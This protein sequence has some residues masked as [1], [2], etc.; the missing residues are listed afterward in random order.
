M[1]LTKAETTNRPP[2]SFSAPNKQAATVGE[3]N[4]LIDE[5][6]GSTGITTAGNVSVGGNLTVTGTT[7]LNGNLVLGDAAADSLIVN[8][9]TTYEGPINYSNATGI[10]AFATG[11]QASATAL[12]EET[13]N[14]TTVATAGDSVKLPAAEAGKHVYVKNSGATA[15][16]IFPA[17]GDS[18]DALAVNLAIRIQP[19]S[20]VNFRAKDGTVWESNVDQ[21]FTL[22]APTT[23]TGQLELKAASSAGNTVTTITNASQA[24]ART[25]TVPDAGANADFVMTAGAQT[26]GGVKD[27]SASPNF[28]LN[29]TFSKEV[30]H[31]LSVST[32]TTAA[33]AGGNLVL[34]SGIGAT[35][36]AGG[37]LSLEAGAGGA[38][39]TGGAIDIK[40]GNGGATSGNSGAVAIY[41]ANETGADLSGAVSVTT[42]T[43]VSADSGALTIATGNVATAG[44][45]GDVNVRTGR[46][47]TSGNSGG[48]NISTGDAA[49]GFSGDVG[50]VTGASS[51]N[52]DTGSISLTTGSAT[53][54]GS[55]DINITTGGTASGVA[56]DI[57]LTPGDGTSAT[58]K[59]VI[60]LNKAVVRKPQS[61][62]VASGGT[63]TGPELVGGLIAATGATGNWNLP[64]AAQIT[65]AIGSTPAGTSFEFIFN[66]Q[67]MT[68]TNTATLVVGAGMS[69]ASA[70]AITGGGALTVTQDTQVTA[71]F[72]IVFDTPTTCKIYRKW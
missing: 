47:T 54:G 48:M 59:P 58:V 11:G 7:T 20:T 40:S 24:A 21:S 44:N 6:E 13:N 30:N 1:A 8:A 69:V 9:T 50:I 14:V 53:I 19:G 29:Q 46:S 43:T 3:L 49:T 55:G 60:S 31:T 35:S 17:T 10:T 70:P 4:R 2:S 56:G 42:G 12:T 39:G 68:A 25:Y 37:V 32:T 62:S 45:G 61:A 71:G 51:V 57:I 38:T 64:T 16:D 18:I 65:T 15:L 41:S 66:A 22:V 23:N 72:Q 34:S 26:V 27:F 5:M 36:G 63:I 28:Q 67:A 33:T 52:G